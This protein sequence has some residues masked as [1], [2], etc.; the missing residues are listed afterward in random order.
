MTRFLP[1]S[2]RKRR[3]SW[4][5][6]DHNEVTHLR[7]VIGW[8]RRDY[9]GVFAGHGKRICSAVRSR[10]EG[11]SSQD[12][13]SIAESWRTDETICGYLLPGRRGFFRTA[14]VRKEV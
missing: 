10:S 4:E 13:G 9:N 14:G 6:Y 2:R 8:D 3:R 7:T 11:Q 12:E 5:R 1:K